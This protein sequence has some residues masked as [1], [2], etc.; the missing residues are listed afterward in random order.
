M[1]K[2]TFGK[3]RGFEILTSILDQ[4][5]K[6]QKRKINKIFTKY[7][8][9]L[10][11][12]QFIHDYTIKIRWLE[13]ICYYYKEKLSTDISINEQIKDFGNNIIVSLYRN[14]LRQ[15]ELRG[16]NWFKRK[17]YQINKN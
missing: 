8:L 5:P 13:R 12:L 10:R 17:E 4:G 16:K 1:H 11:E 6:D 14:K 7:I 9:E 15:W 3:D 2:H